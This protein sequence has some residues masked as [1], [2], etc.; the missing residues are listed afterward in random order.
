MGISTA[1]LDPT[2]ISPLDLC[3]FCQ[4]FPRHLFDFLL[5]LFTCALKEERLSALSL[6]EN[7]RSIMD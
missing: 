6:V 2:V 5:L 4:A 3:H 1:Q 7:V